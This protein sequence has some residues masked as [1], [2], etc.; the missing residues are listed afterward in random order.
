MG[1][2]RYI[3]RRYQRSR[4]R[5]RALN[6]AAVIAVAGITVGVFVLNVVLAVM[7][8]FAA[9]LQ[10]NFVDTMPMI[11]VTTGAAEGFGDLERTIATIEAEPGV[12]GVS[13]QIRQEVIV[14]KRRLFGSPISRGAIS[15]GVDTRRIDSVLPF[16]ENLRPDASVAGELDAAAGEAPRV[17]LGSELA[18]SLWAALGDTVLV[19]APRE[20]IS[21]GELEAE[22]RRFVVAGFFESGMYE[23]DSRFVFLALDEARGFF[24]YGRDGAGIIGVRVEDMMTAD[25]V[26]DSLEVRLGSSYRAIDWMALNATIFR[27][28]SVEKALMFLLISLVVLV[29]A[30]N[31]IGILTMMVGER[32]REVGILLAMGASR[33]QIQWIFTFNGMWFGTLGVALGSLLGWLGCLFLI[34]VG[35][36]I[37]ADLYF[38]DSM[39]CI[40]RWSD[41]AIVAVATLT[42][43]FLATLLPSHEASRLDPMAI[44]RYT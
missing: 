9:E 4:R 32:G 25:A 43:T 27:W 7:N 37:P 15:W 21:L 6:R 34:H 16:S 17:V 11:S 40:P 20:E 29:A 26:A 14:S 12:T 31:I 18:T 30:F 5:S 24:G 28:I 44:I 22:T 33:R 8:G 36:P 38:I 3:A 2:S 1:V 41:F 42:L 13:P 23:F 19:T 39:P 10:R 35:L